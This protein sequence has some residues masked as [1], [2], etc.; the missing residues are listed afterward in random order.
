MYN[1]YINNIHNILIQTNISTHKIYLPIQSHNINNKIIII[2]NKLISYSKLEYLNLNYQLNPLSNYKDKIISK[3]SMESKHSPIPEVYP[4]SKN[5][6]N[7]III[8]LSF[9]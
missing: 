4:N 3:H 5:L 6:I 9:N 7:I 2:I 8:L 1:I